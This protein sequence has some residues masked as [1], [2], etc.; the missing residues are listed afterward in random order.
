MTRYMRRLA[1]RDL[2]LDRAMIP[3]GSCTMKLNATAEM[4]PV[5]WPEFAE[6][7]PFV[8]AD[9]AIGYAELINDLSGKLCRITGYDAISHAAELGSARRVSRACWRSAPIT[10]AA[11]KA[12]RNVCLIPPSAHGT[13]PASA[14]HGRH[15]GGRGRLR[16][17]RQHR[18]RRLPGQGRATRAQPRGADDHLSRRPT[19]CSRRRVREICADRP[20]QRRPGVSRRRQHERAGRTAP[21]RATSAPTCATSTC[22]R[23]SASRTAAAAPA[24]GRSASSRISRPS[25]RTSGDDGRR[26]ADRVGRRRMARHRSCRSRGAI[27]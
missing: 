2:A 16:R 24:W 20:R 3:L 11:A 15:E 23:R 5:T 7:H 22:T 21:A 25:F 6:M 26:C 13:N 27:A 19:A 12:H 18:R 17:R 9:Q 8:P 1:D 14:S 4:L 10:R